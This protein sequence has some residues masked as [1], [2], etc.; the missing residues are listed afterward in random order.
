MSG[1]TSDQVSGQVLD[2]LG[3]VASTI[4]RLGLVESID[5]RLPVSK[6]K[7][8]KVGMG[9]RVAAMILNGLGFIDDR[10]YLFPDFLENKPV[11]R[12]LGEG[13][14]AADF[15][16]DVL[17]RCLDSIHA[18]G[19]TKLFSELSFEIGAQ[20]G[21]LGRSA[22]IDT[23]TLSLF[24][25]YEEADEDEL[26]P[27]YGYSKQKRMDLKQVVLLLATSGKGNLPIWMAAHNGNASDQKTLR[28]AAKRIDDFCAQLEGAPSFIYVADSAMYESCLKDGEQINW[29]SRVPERIKA[30]KTLVQTEESQISWQALDSGYRIAPYQSDYKN[31]KQR[32]LLVYSEQAHQRE[33]KTLDRRI[34]KEFDEKGKAL[35][36]LC[37]KKFGCESDATESLAQFKKT[38][39]LHSTKAK[40][41]VLMGHAS[42][43]Q[44]KK[45]AEKIV[46]GYKI[47]GQLEQDLASIE[48]LRASKGRFILATNT[49]EEELSNEEMLAEYKAQSQVESGFKFIKN[50]TFEV[51]SIFL[52]KPER[53]E[54]LMMVMSLCLMTYNVA[55]HH[56]RET[57]KARNETLLTQT[58]KPTQNPTM[59]WIFRQFHGVQI[60]CLEIGEK[61]EKLVV[62][63]KEH[64]ARIIEYFGPK[65]ME[66]YA[67]KPAKLK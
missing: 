41:E 22:H 46:K 13:L 56:L 1:L 5:K 10:L 28:Q 33:S 11:D 34:Q 24:G 54:A 53:I 27:A 36:R 51:D 65:A 6:N 14:C 45:G 66:I 49:P 55:Q 39:K 42:K 63:V 19:T 4:D 17:G 2:H 32:W 21:L 30:A 23:T 57:L 12:L 50:D 9:S 59:S 8:S 20:L 35:W 3:L 58:K 25:S 48:K 15:N 16:D 37:N 26:L 47:K 38:L 67:V 62:N 52:K 31:V 18:Y 43:G 44:P 29:L 64:L 40:V 60:W 61:V 7:G